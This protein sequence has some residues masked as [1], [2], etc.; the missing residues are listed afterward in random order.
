MPLNTDR[1]SNNSNKGTTSRIK[2]NRIIATGREQTLPPI[3]LYYVRRYFLPFL[4][5]AG[6]L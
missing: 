3:P 2:R 6:F 5:A 4:A 1:T